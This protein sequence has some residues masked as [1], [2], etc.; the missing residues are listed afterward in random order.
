MEPPSLH[1]PPPD[2]HHCLYIYFLF[3]AGKGNRWKFVFTSSFFKF[4]LFLC[5]F[6][7][8]V[9]PHLGSPGLPYHHIFG[10]GTQMLLGS[11]Q[12]DTSGLTTC[13]LLSIARTLSLHIAD[14]C[15]C[16]LAP[17][18]WAPSFLL[19]ATFSASPAPQEPAVRTCSKLG[20]EA[21]TPLSLAQGKINA[22]WSPSR[23]K[24]PR[25]WALWWWGRLIP[26]SR[27]QGAAKRTMILKFQSKW[28]L[29]AKG[30]VS[31]PPINQICKVEKSDFLGLSWSLLGF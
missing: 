3:F 16:V 5:N 25:R 9:P 1:P 8:S 4:H 12:P 6:H 17:Q 30:T 26:S 31:S 14:Q 11:H 24:G 10:E 27:F 19:E 29:P 13:P 15:Q 21:H 20:T 18:P 28:F 22:T 7:N 2:S 23:D